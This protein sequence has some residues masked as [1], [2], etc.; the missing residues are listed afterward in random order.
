M[1]GGR[2]VVAVTA[3]SS[4]NGGQAENREDFETHFYFKV[5]LN[6]SMSISVGL[7]FFFQK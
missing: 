7:I 4:S 1:I 2:G 3:S 6:F 5:W